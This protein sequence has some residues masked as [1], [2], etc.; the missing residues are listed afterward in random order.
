[1]TASM[2][3]N[4]MRWMF[5]ALLLTASMIAPAVAAETE[6][7]FQIHSEL[8]PERPLKP[9]EFTWAPDEG[10]S[11]KLVIVAD[12]KTQLLHVYRG[13]REI[14]ISTISSG[15][16]GF[17]TPPGV[18]QILEK[19]AD[20]YSDLYDFSPMPFMQRLTWDGVALHGGVVPGRAA[21]HGCIRLPEAFAQIL[22]HETGMG[23]TVIVSPDWLGTAD[24]YQVAWDDDPAQLRLDA[25]NR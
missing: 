20:H 8:A 16:K 12:L 3:E 14:G 2:G 10:K 23:G 9:G 18:Y 25:L 7:V 1:M 24:S 19:D 5:A 11:G 6:G 17:E 22:F 13:G 21:S 4:G 15:R